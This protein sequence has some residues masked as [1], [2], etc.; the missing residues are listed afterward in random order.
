MPLSRLVYRLV[1]KLKPDIMLFGAIRE[2]YARR[3]LGEFNYVLD[4][5]E[6]PAF[7]D[8]P[9]DCDEI[10]RIANAD[11]NGVVLIT[12]LYC[13]RVPER[14]A[15]YL[16]SVLRN[17]Q[18]GLFN[19]VC[20]LFEL[21]NGGNHC[22]LIE[23]LRQNGVI[24]IGITG[25]PTFTQLFSFANK[26]LEGRRIVI[27]NGDIFFNSSLSKAWN[28]LRHN[29]L[30]ALTRWD[31]LPN[32]D[33]HLQNQF[34]QRTGARHLLVDE[35][36]GKQDAWIFRSPLEPD[37]SCPFA[38]GTLY[39]DGFLNTQF[40]KSHHI[41]VYNPSLDIQACHL[42]RS[43]ARHADVQH[44]RKKQSMF[45]WAMSVLG[46][47]P[48]RVDWCSFLQI[49]RDQ[50]KLTVIYFAAADQGASAVAA[51]VS[52][53]YRRPDVRCIYLMLS[54]NRQAVNRKIADALKSLE[55]LTVRYDQDEA[56]GAVETADATVEVSRKY[57]SGVHAAG[58][59]QNKAVLR[60][61]RQPQS[62]DYLGI[63][64]ARRLKLVEYQRGGLDKKL[65]RYIHD[66]VDRDTLQFVYDKN[67]AEVGKAVDK[68]RAK[69]H[70]L[71]TVEPAGDF[72]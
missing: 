42:H 22:D 4:E 10:A 14:A 57:V 72:L 1:R 3:L 7:V 39:C 31:L 47:I 49:E 29:M 26:Y 11:K 19:E 13:E 5:R 41:S 35:S 48:S 12:S 43:V 34:V 69:N 17:R 50:R 32:G 52:T 28:C 27:A 71:S 67:N 8:D 15:E 64:I 65:A 25:R 16:Q 60:L 70:G 20:V 37:V 6:L 46:Y 33:L 56:I 68:L 21:E 2:V 58:V 51:D 55:G 40:L 44:T 54:E 9:E 36:G 30:F 53:I 38:L 23:T 62:R 66:D 63:T 59:V 61:S 45:S 24:V 18:S